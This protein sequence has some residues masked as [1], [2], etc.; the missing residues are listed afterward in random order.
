MRDTLQISF[1]LFLL[2][3]TIFLSSNLL[4]SQTLK[5]EAKGKTEANSTNELAFDSFAQQRQLASQKLYENYTTPIPTCGT[6]SSLNRI[7]EKKKDG[8]IL[9]IEDNGSKQ[10]S[11]SPDSNLIEVR[12]QRNLDFLIKCEDK[13]NC[14]SLDSQGK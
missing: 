5:I 14:I 13:K 2:I 12:I 6:S 9:I 1:Q 4:H 7:E 11:I 10:W 3:V 8:S